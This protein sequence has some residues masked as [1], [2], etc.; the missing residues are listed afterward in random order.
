MRDIAVHDSP[1]RGRGV[2]AARD[3]RAGEIIEECPAIVIPDRDIPKIDETVL[4]HYYFGWSGPEG[5]GAIGL[6]FASLYNHSD[7]PNAECSKDSEAR[8]IRFV[9]LRDITRGEEICFRYNTGGPDV[10]LWFTPC[11]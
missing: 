8:I 9:A 6:G 7:R 1:G 11:D 5:S 10:P 4:W 2:F 3:F